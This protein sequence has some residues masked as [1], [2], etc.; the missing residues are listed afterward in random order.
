MENLDMNID[1]ELLLKAM[2]ESS[3][4]NLHQNQEQPQNLI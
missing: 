1:P 2:E 3:Q 4:E